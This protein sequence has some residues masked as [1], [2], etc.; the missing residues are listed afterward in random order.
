MKKKSV[1][2]KSLAF[3]MA[4]VMLVCATPLAGLIGIDLSEIFVTDAKAASEFMNQFTEG[5]FT[6]GHYYYN[7]DEYRG[8]AVIAYNGTDTDIVIP[9]T[10]AQGN[11]DCIPSGVFRDNKNLTSV[12][13]SEGI[14]LIERS[15]FNGCENIKSITFPDSLTE[16]EPYAFDSCKSLKSI[17]LP[18]NLKVISQDMLIRCSGLESITIP[19]GVTRIDDQAFWAC[20]SLKS[21]NIPG[22]VKSVGSQ[23]FAYC[24]SLETVTF[25]EGTK[26]VGSIFEG[27]TSLKTVS[28]PNSLTNISCSF[29]DCKNLESINV[30]DGN[31]TYYDENGVLFEK[32]ENGIRLVA[33][34]AAKTAKSYTVPENVTEIG[35]CA[36]YNCVNLETVNI[37]STAN[38]TSI[39]DYA[40]YNCKS[41]KSFNIPETVTTIGDSAFAYCESLTEIT[42]PS[43]VTEISGA[44]FFNCSNLATIN[45]HDG[46]T[47]YGGNAFWNTAFYN[48]KN[49]WDNGCLYVGTFLLDVDYETVSGDL[50]V[51]DGTI[52]ISDGALSYLPYVTSITI[53]DSVKGKLHGI[54]GENIK[55][56][57]IGSGITSLA[58]Y[59]SAVFQSCKNLETI[60]VSSDN[61]YL[62]VEN[63][64]LYNIDKS[65]LLRYPAKKAGTDFTVPEGVTGITEFA[66]SDTTYLKNITLSSSVRSIGNTSMLDT[67]AFSGCKALENIYVADGNTY[68]FSDNGVLY[69]I[70]S[71][72]TYYKLVYYPGANPRE[73][74]TLL[75]N[76]E[77]IRTHAFENCVNLKILN[78]NAS[79]NT[80]ELTPDYYGFV[81]LES[82]NVEEGNTSYSSI[83]G[84]LY[85]AEKT[86]ILKYPVASKR[87][88]YTVP[89]SV[90]Y[91]REYAFKNIKYLEEVIFSD[92]FLGTASF[93]R[94]ENLR[95]VDLGENVLEIRSFDYCT[96]LESVTFGNKVERIGTFEYCVSLKSIVIPDGVTEISPYAFEGCTALESVTLSKNLKVIPESAF[97]GS[98]IK[99]IVI[100]DGVEA[101][102]YTAFAMCPNLET[103]SIPASVTFIEQAAFALSMNLKNLDVAPENPVYSSENGVLYNKDKTVI[104][105]YPV[106]K[107]DSYFEIPDGVAEIGAAAFGA[108]PNIESVVIPASVTK[109][110]EEA[111]YAYPE[112]GYPTKLSDVYYKGS[113][114]DW[115][116]V[117]KEYHAFYN[118]SELKFHYNY[119][120][121][122]EIKAPTDSADGE[123]ITKCNCC[124]KVVTTE[125]IP[126]FGHVFKAGEWS[127]NGFS[128]AT[129]SFI[130]E[131]NSNHV[132][133]VN[134][135]ITSE[136]T[137]AT[138]NNDG[139]TVYTAT[140]T[141][142]GKTYTDEKTEVIPASGPIVTENKEFGVSVIY[143][144]DCFN[145]EVELIVTEMDDVMGKND[146]YFIDGKTHLP[147]SLYNI[148]MQNKNSEVVQPNAGKKVTI[149]VPIPENYKHKTEFNVYHWFEG[150]GYECLRSKNNQV[151]TENGYIFFTVGKFSVFEIFTT[152]DAEL[153]KAPNSTKCVYKGELNLDGIEIAVT[154]DGKT[155]I[156]TDTSKMRVEG[157][158]STKLGEQTVKVY[159]GEEPVEIKVTVEYAWWQWIIRI[160]L[161]GFLWY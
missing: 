154:K 71:P 50:I 15:A 4:A 98:G 159:Y 80:F 109:I 33:Y 49:N 118:P 90:L 146:T 13:I 32:L 151:W 25:N 78:I 132:E 39:G 115:N 38:I 66:F 63:G 92:N 41:L 119:A 12:V 82:F 5:D 2:K 72:S 143:D 1:I 79:F 27:C 160:L 86:A 84:V 10:T 152:S 60:E 128:S 3:A 42:I 20:S 73:E 55:S 62:T 150:G 75:D 138:S 21:L 96:K 14:E 137:P 53:P 19:D 100:H 123:K 121:V 136:T 7:V 97:I 59:G 91:A 57:K 157:L 106:S 11:V 124:G 29:S 135:V 125:S 122:I 145:E 23:A 99:D 144:D 149:K 35:D 58:D 48:D 18:K 45:L 17:V 131:A 69:E 142:D 61:K 81:A 127:W 158:D 54:N 141:F 76:T 52:Q 95:S 111:F 74:Y 101:I 37:P 56:I 103:V 47:S 44:L 85:D 43:G 113:E 110:G 120:P 8:I 87:T 64:V 26:S 24:S 105:Q 22:S 31:P 28:I 36:F 140:V 134:A 114:S 51:R 112:E 116:S 139:K 147:V 30:A 65:R 126:A 148:K 94:C 34:P 67:H 161:L 68:Y 6:F 88:S 107:E 70:S 108:T 40:F 77:R 133:K 89:D 130:C 46:I 9:G 153:K 93:E 16:I 102:G 129:L 104:M 155:E 156:I 83:D 117:T